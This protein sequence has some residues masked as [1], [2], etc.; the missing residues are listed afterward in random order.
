MQNKS[1]PTGSRAALACLAA[2]VIVLIWSGIAPKQRSTWFLEVLPVLSALPLILFTWRRFPLTTL[3]TVVITP[4]AIVLTAGIGAAVAV[5]FFSRMHDR[6]L[7][8][9]K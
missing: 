5:I 7:V 1:T 4:H 9:L 6:A 3:L 8:A 2:T